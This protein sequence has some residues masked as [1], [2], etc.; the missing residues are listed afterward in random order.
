MS[1]CP[2][3]SKKR[4]TDGSTNAATLSRNSLDRVNFQA[5]CRQDQFLTDKRNNIIYINKPFF[6]FS[7]INS[8]ITFHLRNLKN[9]IADFILSRRSKKQRHPSSSSSS[10]A[11]ARLKLAPSRHGV[12]IGT[13]MRQE[14]ALFHQELEKLDARRELY[15]GERV[16]M[17]LDMAWYRSLTI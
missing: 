7:I 4:V 13:S 10:S 5:F 15:K 9:Y 11:A 3:N 8:L 16:C 2:V 17:V 1:K 14:R 6:A 12:S